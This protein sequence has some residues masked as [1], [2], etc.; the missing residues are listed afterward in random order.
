MKIKDQ[1]GV[2]IVVEIVRGV[3]VVV[4]DKEIAIEL[5]EIN[6]TGGIIIITTTDKVKMLL[7]KSS[8][9]NT[10]AITTAKTRGGVVSRSNKEVEEVGI[11]GALA[12]TTKLVGETTITIVT[13]SF[14]EIREQAF[15]PST[16][17]LQLWKRSWRTRKEGWWWAALM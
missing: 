12:E 17:A 14:S 7:L 11:M 8:I 4:E 16:G 15:S 13:T 1:V 3:E 9:T 5:E 6:L 2:E 10:T